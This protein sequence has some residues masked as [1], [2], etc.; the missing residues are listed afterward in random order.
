MKKFLILFVTTLSLSFFVGC[1]YDDLIEEPN[2][3]SFQFDKSIMVELGG[4]TTYDVNVY[5]GNVSGSDRT[6]DVQVREASSLGGE[7]YTVPATVTI[8]ANSNEAVISVGIT[9][10]GIS[11]NGET[12]VLGL[13]SADGVYVGPDISLNIGLSC[14]P[15]F[16]IH[17]VFDG[18]ASETTWNVKDAEGNVRLSGGPYTDGTAVGNIL[19][20][21]PPGDYT[22]T[23]NDAFG[24]GLTFPEI[25]SVTLKYGGEELVVIPGNFGATTTVSFTLE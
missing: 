18:Y 6:F 20:C 13:A 23:V 7:S 2:Y 14:D 16:G 9:D 22:F 19:R 24:D 15:Q 5:T 8:P 3:V 12:L 25:G 1:D 4:S 21:I 17:F 10:N 11:P